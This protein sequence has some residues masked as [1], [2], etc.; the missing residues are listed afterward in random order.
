MLKA[1]HEK[2]RTRLC[3]A[4]SEADFAPADCEVLPR[5]ARSVDATTALRVGAR[6]RAG[7]VGR[8]PNC[9]ARRLRTSGEVLEV[10]RG[11]EALDSAFED[12]RV[13]PSSYTYD[14]LMEHAP[15]AQRADW[16]ARAI[17]TARGADLGANRPAPYQGDGAARGSR[18]GGFTRRAH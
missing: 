17:E 13:A 1:V 4:L 5:C 9:P 3:R 16:R 8:W 11:A 7:E 10:G 6:L 2:R 12:Y 18:R 15:M 14:A